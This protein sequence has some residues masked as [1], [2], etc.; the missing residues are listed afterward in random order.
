MFE[1]VTNLIEGRFLSEWDGDNVQYDN[2][3]YRP[4][5]GQPFVR[6]NIQWVDTN[7]VSIGGRIKAE[8]YVQVGVFIPSNTSTVSALKMAD[9]VG[10]IFNKWQSGNLIFTVARIIRVGNF[11]EWYQVNVLI[12]F[13]YAKCI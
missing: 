13:T 2:V 6:L 7:I 5:V 11:K 3:Q 9:Q 4:V 10:N 1:E 8:G 12:P